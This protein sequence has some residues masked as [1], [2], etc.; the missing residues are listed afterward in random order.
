M[1]A[2]KKSGKT[3]SI[4]VSNFQWPHLEAILEGAQFVPTVNQL[5]FHPYLQRSHNYVAWMR[6]HGIEVSALKGLAPVP[7]A[8]GGP[9]DGPL[10]AIAQRHDV[11][12]NAVLPKWH[13]NQNVIPVT[14][15]SSEDRMKCYLEALKLNLT[16]E[17]QE[18]SRRLA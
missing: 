5:E 12:T 17:E 13:M 2:V 14:T 8:K 16:A 6:E 11:D 7:T 10:S 18:E 4:G 9:L 1:E 15:T 3:E